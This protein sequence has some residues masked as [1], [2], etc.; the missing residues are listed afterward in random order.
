[1]W[2]S[3]D[4]DGLILMLIGSNT[5]HRWRSGNIDS[6]I[7]TEDKKT[8]ALLLNNNIMVHLTNAR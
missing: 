2:K 5:V 6:G 4:Q 1:M 7:V 8:F 3:A